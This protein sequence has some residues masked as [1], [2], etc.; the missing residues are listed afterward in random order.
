MLLI[1]ILGDSHFFLL[2]NKNM[3]TM[4]IFLIIFGFVSVF[5]IVFII[6]KKER[7]RQ[8]SKCFIIPFLLAAYIAGGG[9]KFLLPIPGLVLGWIGDVLLI[10]IQKRIYFMLGLASF[11]LGHIFT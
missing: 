5:H 2:Y 6:Q 8:I 7:L 1:F 10:K 9:T 4:L 11:L 3:N